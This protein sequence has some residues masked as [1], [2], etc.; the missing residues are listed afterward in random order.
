MYETW[1]TG[2]HNSIQKVLLQIVRRMSCVN[3]VLRKIRYYFDEQN[4]LEMEIENGLNIDY[5]NNIPAI[6]DNN[7]ELI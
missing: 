1:H 4:D 7:N 5:N 2:T 6:D 3:L